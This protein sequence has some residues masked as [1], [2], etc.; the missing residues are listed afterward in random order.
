[1]ATR[2]FIGILNEDKTVDYIYCHWDGYPS[3]MLPILTKNYSTEEK[4]KELLEL[5]DISVLKPL[6]SPPE[7]EEHTF[8]DPHSDTTIAYHRDRGEEFHK[9][10]TMSEA[11][12]NREY[13]NCNGVDY[14]YLFKDNEWVVL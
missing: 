3:Y 6:V 7:G 4:V 14:G 8:R 13:V 5:G 12:Y 10:S 11:L 9:R 2:S 1:M